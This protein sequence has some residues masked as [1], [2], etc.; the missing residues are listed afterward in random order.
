[1]ANETKNAFQDT[2]RPEG[3][4]WT[5]F[6]VAAE[7]STAQITIPC[8]LTWTKNVAE[9]E[10]GDD[11][12]KKWSVGIAIPKTD[13]AKPLVDALR[14]A[15]AD[16]IKAAGIKGAFPS[17]LRDGA[18]KDSSGLYVKSSGKLADFMYTTGKTRKAPRCLERGSNGS[19]IEFDAKSVNAGGFAMLS[20]SLIVVGH[21]SDS[22]KGS[23]LWFDKILWLGGGNQIAGGGGVSDEEAFDFGGDD[24][25]SSGSSFI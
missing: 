4:S 24:T 23:S 21:G 3:F 18:A 5:K 2:A 17:F 13:E 25:K 8:L 9:P 1:M 12:K 10:I 14:K 22:K 19:F 15:E 16:I 20:A 7:G 6:K 11:E